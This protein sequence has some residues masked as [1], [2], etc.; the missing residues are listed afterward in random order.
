MILLMT[1]TLSKDG[2][3]MYSILYTPRVCGHHELT[4]LIN[5][6]Q[7]SGNPFPTHASFHPIQ[8]M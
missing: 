4:V 5:S 7:V 1:V 2:L 3:G 6:Q 8:P